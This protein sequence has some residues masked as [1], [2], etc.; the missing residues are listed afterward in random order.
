MPRRNSALVTELT[1]RNATYA[2]NFANANL[3]AKPVLG[4]AVV[5][6]MDARLPVLTLLGLSQGDAHVIRNAGGV[7][8]DDVIRSLCLSQ[9]ALGTKDVILIHHTDCG[10]QKVTEKGFKDELAAE[11][12]VRPSWAVESFT[13]PFENVRS[14]VKKL[15]MSPFMAADSRVIG[16]V[17]N[18]DTGVLDLVE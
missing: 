11:L 9:R 18:V 3:E 5:A 1:Q 15:L 12:G 14:S 10:L 2:R 13:D 8:T 17:Y 7:V 16:F 6:C 4:V